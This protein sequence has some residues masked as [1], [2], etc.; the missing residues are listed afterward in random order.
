MTP[1]TN[2][3]NARAALLLALAG[4]SM[5][6]ESAEVAR[7]RSLDKNGS[8]YVLRSDRPP[9]SDPRSG[10]GPFP[11]APTLTVV[12]GAPGGIG[13]LDGVGRAARIGLVTALASADGETFYF[14][15]ATFHTLR[16]LTLSTR[17]VKTVAGLADEPGSSDGEAV[18][19]RL[20]G[21]SGLAMDGTSGVFVA[22]RG[23]QTIRRYDI[24]TRT[25]ST[26]AGTVGKRG[27]ADGPAASATFD[28]P[29]A[30]AFVPPRLF[31]TDPGSHAVR[32]LDVATKTVS[33]AATTMPLR[34]PVGIAWPGGGEIFVSDSLLDAVYGIDVSTGKTRVVAG[35]G[36]YGYPNHRD[37]VGQRARF[38]DPRELT[39]DAAGTS[40]FVADEHNGSI[41]RVR[42][43]DGEVTT[44]ASLAIVRQGRDGDI[45]YFPVHPRAVLAERDGKHVLFAERGEIRRLD[46]ASLTVD[47]VA[48]TAHSGSP[49]Q[50][51][52][53]SGAHLGSIESLEAIAP[54][55][56][57]AGDCLTGKIRSVDLKSGEV[58]T[59]TLDRVTKLGAKDVAKFHCPSGIASDWRG[60]LVVADR[61]N[62]VLQ[63]VTFSPANVSTIAGKEQTCGA[64]DGTLDEARFCGPNRVAYD[65]TTDVVYVTD[66]SAHTIRAVDLVGRTVRTLAGTAFQKG[67]SDGVGASA[68]FSFPAGLALDGK[69]LYVA[70]RD[71][72][73]VR[74]VDTGSGAVTPFAGRCGERG[75]ADGEASSATFDEPHELKL[76]PSGKTLFLIDRRTVRAIDV[77]TRR[78]SRVV[79]SAAGIGVVPGPLPAPLGAPASLL[80]LDDDA[81]VLADTSEGVIVRATKVRG[82]AP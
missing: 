37:G 61:A 15:D 26:I 36:E 3:T 23:N 39:A 79:R 6:C 9:A 62:G 53:G 25:L 31:V 59:V 8:P 1:R 4:A 69:K 49:Y 30:I 55:R 16:T 44:Q 43:S 80:P 11:D 17:E 28:Y 41:R 64:A 24:A 74:V 22:D 76:S 77:A 71:N 20:F 10:Y 67:H 73:C 57:L 75:G 38:Y 35:L 5:G 50:D 13:A 72:H 66:S 18:R 48:G 42:L 29:S 21:P 70:D 12:A 47:V 40:I 2:K 52:T 60:G 68:R 51:G 82:L 78:S 7:Q 45:G 32:I 63:S 34:S 81:L 65:H 54:G 56:A 58:D 19:S 46:L 33:T 27:A 14:A